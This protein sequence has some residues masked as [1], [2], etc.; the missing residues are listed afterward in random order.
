VSASYKDGIV[1]TKTKTGARKKN[2][3]KKPLNGIKHTYIT[4]I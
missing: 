4:Y 2:N 3:N 1:V